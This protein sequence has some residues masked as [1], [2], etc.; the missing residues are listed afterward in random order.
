GL[1]LSDGSVSEMKKS[2][3]TGVPY[4]MGLIKRNFGRG[5]VA[6][7]HDGGGLGGGGRA[8]YFPDKSSSIVILTNTGLLSGKDQVREELWTKILYEVF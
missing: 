1:L 7:G 5:G 2:V 4:G 8:Y 3:I 6:F